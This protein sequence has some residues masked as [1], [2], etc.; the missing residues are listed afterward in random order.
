MCSAL[1]LSLVYQTNTSPSTSSIHSFIPDQTTIISVADQPTNHTNRT[2]TMRTCKC[3]ITQNA[4][5]TLSM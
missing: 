5:L 4:I 3:P 1:S 2:V